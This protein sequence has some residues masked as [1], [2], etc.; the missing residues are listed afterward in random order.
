MYFIDLYIFLLYFERLNRA[1]WS[2]VEH[3]I[4]LRWCKWFKWLTSQ[5]ILWELLELP[6]AALEVSGT[7]M[8]NY[9]EI[10]L[11]QFLW[12]VAQKARTIIGLIVSAI[13]HLRFAA[14][15][16]LRLWLRLAAMEREPQEVW[17]VCLYD[18]LCGLLAFQC[19]SSHPMEVNMIHLNSLR[20]IRIHP[21]YKLKWLLYYIAIIHGF[22]HVLILS[23]SSLMTGI[24][25]SLC[26]A[27]VW[28][29]HPVGFLHHT[30]K[31][32]KN[33]SL[34]RAPTWHAR[35]FTFCSPTTLE[36]QSPLFTRWEVHSP[37][38]EKFIWNNYPVLQISVVRGAKSTNE[39]SHCVGWCRW[40]HNGLR[41]WGW[42]YCWRHRHKAL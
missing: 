38:V 21:N 40:D 17:H 29:K 1:W 30:R 22:I 16:E 26:F 23:C 24:F 34:C 14:W 18:P 19:I 4:S 13:H 12:I 32:K 35:F 3:S 6:S 31:Q 37:S 15:Q 33:P 42:L 28:P 36:K 11:C 8:P 5:Q 9:Y 7:G 20:F 39:V 10:W 25:W 41:I 27:R 2:I